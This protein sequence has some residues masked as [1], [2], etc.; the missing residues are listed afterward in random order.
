MICTPGPSRT[1]KNG[2][3]APCPTFVFC[4]LQAVKSQQQLQAV[5][6]KIGGT[7]QQST[8]NGEIAIVVVKIKVRSLNLG[9][10]N[11]CVSQKFSQTGRLIQR[12]TFDFNSRLRVTFQTLTKYRV[13]GYR[14][15]LYVQNWLET[16]SFLR[17]TPRPGQHHHYSSLLLPVSDCPP[18][19]VSIYKNILLWNLCKI[20]LIHIII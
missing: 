7:Q 2:G 8:G 17:V 15:L 11:S 18:G 19:R 5:C 16:D 13:F 6:M 10:Q 1:N 12:K 14:L 20:H 4:V 3:W 9:F